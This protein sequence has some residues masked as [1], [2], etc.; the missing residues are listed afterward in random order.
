MAILVVAAFSETLKE[1]VWVILLGVWAAVS[2]LL[3]S[4]GAFFNGSNFL[5]LWVLL[6]WKCNLTHYLLLHI[7]QIVSL[8]APLGWGCYAADSS[9]D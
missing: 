4:S 7:S 5:V 9:F 8:V 1:G 6:L 2:P 3:L